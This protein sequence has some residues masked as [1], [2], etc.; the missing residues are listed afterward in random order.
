MKSVETEQLSRLFRSVNSAMTSSEKHL[1]C[2]RSTNGCA[3][4]CQYSMPV[5]LSNGAEKIPDYFS[6]KMNRI[7]LKNVGSR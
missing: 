4:K 2:G 7:I 5:F 3:I 1:F 6:A